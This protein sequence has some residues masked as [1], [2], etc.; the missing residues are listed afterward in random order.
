MWVYN[1]LP[2]LDSVSRKT[3]LTLWTNKGNFTFILFVYSRLLS[4]ENFIENLSESI[5][6]TTTLVW[7][8]IFTEF[9]IH[10]SFDLNQ[11]YVY[12]LSN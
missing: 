2:L 11:R 6:F 3:L 7:S 4:I 5:V 10:L 1:L 12:L 8:C 9:H